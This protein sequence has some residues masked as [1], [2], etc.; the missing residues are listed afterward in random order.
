MIGGVRQCLSQEMNL[1]CSDENGEGRR[2]SGEHCSGSFTWTLVECEHFRNVKE[3]Y[4]SPYLALDWPAKLK[5]KSER[6]QKGQWNAQT[7]G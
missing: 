2:D 1:T 5:R 7:D 6:R 3:E 4:I